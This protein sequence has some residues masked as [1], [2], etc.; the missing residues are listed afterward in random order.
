MYNWGCGRDVVWFWGVAYALD[1]IVVTLKLSARSWSL[2]VCYVAYTGVNCA[3]PA[4]Y[5]LVD[6]LY[7]M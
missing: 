2:H 5:I 3:V 1:L 4:C 7:Y 6:V